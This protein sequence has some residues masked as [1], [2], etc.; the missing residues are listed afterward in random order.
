MDQLS[1]SYDNGDMV[2]E[3]ERKYKS[4]D[5]DFNESYS[6]EVGLRIPDLTIAGY[7]LNRR[8]SDVLSEIEK[9][10]QVREEQLEKIRKDLA[11]LRQL[12]EQYRYLNNRETLVDA[13]AS[14]KK[15]LQIEGIDP[16]VLLSVKENIIKNQIKKTGVKYGI[17]RNYIFVL[18]N[19]GML[20]DTPIRN[21]LSGSQET[22]Q[23]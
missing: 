1:F 14:L 7:E 15:F 22:V 2:D 6:F 19:A 4:K 23:W 3:Y 12:I 9:C 11:D 17:L 8:K 18:D 13:E 5:Y 10:E 20:S 16:L 21:Y